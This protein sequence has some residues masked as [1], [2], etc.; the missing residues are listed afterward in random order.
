MKTLTDRELLRVLGGDGG[1]NPEDPE[2][3]GGMPRRQPVW[4]SGN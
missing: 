4:E 3:D 1:E 2:T